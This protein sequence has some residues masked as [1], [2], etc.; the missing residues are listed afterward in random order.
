[1]LIGKFRGTKIE[2]FCGWGSGLS[3]FILYVQYCR[4]IE[5]MNHYII[6][7]II[8]FIV[9]VIACS[10]FEGKKDKWQFATFFS[11]EALIMALWSLGFLVSAFFSKFIGFS[12]D[13][14]LVV[15][16]TLMCFISVCGMLGSIEAS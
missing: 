14:C 3:L 12:D 4:T 16:S 13:F 2:E 10:F 5:K 8:F 11:T 9:L 6:F 7:S 1:M 15:T